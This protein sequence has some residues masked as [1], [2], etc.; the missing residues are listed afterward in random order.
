MLRW[1][2]QPI[3]VLAIA[4]CRS[5]PLESKHKLMMTTSIHV[6]VRMAEFGDDLEVER[7]VDCETIS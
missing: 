1:V 3:C 2:H 7:D 4:G 5:R 6:L